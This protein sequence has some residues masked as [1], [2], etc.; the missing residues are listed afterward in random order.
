MFE[1]LGGR[2]LVGFL[3]VLALATILCFFGKIDGTMWMTTA[4]ASFGAYAG[5]N[6]LAKKWGNGGL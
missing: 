5:S 4:L 1:L 2:K 3:L 6:V